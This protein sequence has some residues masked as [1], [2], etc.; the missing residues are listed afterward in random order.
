MLTSPSCRRWRPDD[1]TKKVPKFTRWEE[2]DH[3]TGAKPRLI[4]GD[5]IT[6]VNGETVAV[7]DLIRISQKNEGKNQPVPTLVSLERDLADLLT[8]V[9]IGPSGRKPTPSSLEALGRGFHSGFDKGIV[10]CLGTA[11]YDQGRPRGS[12]LSGYTR[13]KGGNSGRETFC[14]EWTAKS[15]TPTGPKMQKFSAT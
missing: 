14:S 9:K 6:A 15:S 12:G 5:A 1:Q 4:P 11:S 3:P 8:V 2:A 10:R 7:D 13:P